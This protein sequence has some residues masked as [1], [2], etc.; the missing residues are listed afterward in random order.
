MAPRD[1]ASKGTRVAAGRQSR[2][3]SPE[4]S[5]RSTSPSC[6]RTRELQEWVQQEGLKVCTVFEG[7]DGAGKGGSIKAITER[8]SPRLFRVVA[9]PAPTEREKSQL[10]LK[11]YVSHVPAAGGSS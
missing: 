7:R 11:R 9:L 8:V 5:T 2:R 4:S 6:T 1:E 3:N 10:Y